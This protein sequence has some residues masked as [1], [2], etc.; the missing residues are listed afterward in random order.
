MSEIEANPNVEAYAWSL[1][2]FGLGVLAEIG[3]NF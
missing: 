2:G 3:A 1:F